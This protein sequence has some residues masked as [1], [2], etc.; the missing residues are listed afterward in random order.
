MEYLLKKLRSLIK[1][2]KK[3]ALLNEKIYSKSFIPLEKV[4]DWYTIL[5][6]WLTKSYWAQNFIIRNFYFL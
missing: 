4:I 3:K 2:K 5:V 6:K 1:Q